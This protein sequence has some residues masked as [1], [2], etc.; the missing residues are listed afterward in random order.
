MRQASDKGAAC[1][2]IESAVENFRTF[3]QTKSATVA[4]VGVMEV[5]MQRVDLTS[6]RRPRL[7]PLP[8]ARGLVVAVTACIAVLLP[9]SNVTASAP[10][11]V[12]SDGRI[13]VAGSVTLEDGYQ[14]VAGIVRLDADGTLDQTFGRRGSLL[15]RRAYGF[16]AVTLGPGDTINAGAEDIY[17]YSSNGTP[18][19]GFGKGGVA[20]T[21]KGGGAAT[22]I[23][24]MI[25][26]PDGGLIAVSNLGGYWKAS[27]PAIGSVIALSGAGRWKER[28]ANCHPL[29]PLRATRGTGR[30][31]P[32][33]PRLRMAP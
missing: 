6:D 3:W 29:N 15:E 19:R 32:T 18:D 2:S 9:V 20:S 13:V 16:S 30:A 7:T 33:S 23:P 31:S 1:R 17:R 5:E 12:Q 10:I 28:S 21:P 26:R 22:S 27:V 25:A 14:P 24:R 8:L 4:D 11:A